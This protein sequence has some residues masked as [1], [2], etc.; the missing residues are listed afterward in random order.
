M[1]FLITVII[2]LMYLLVMLAGYK[3]GF[4]KQGEYY[5]GLIFGILVTALFSTIIEKFVRDI[6][7]NDFH[8]NSHAGLIIIGYLGR[9]LVF[10]VVFFLCRLIVRKL[11]SNDEKTTADRIAGALFGIVK[12]TILIWLLNTLLS[13]VDAFAGVNS[14]L[15]QST[16]Y[17][18]I[19]RFNIV[20]YIF[21]I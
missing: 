2:I 14:F 6:A 9:L 7:V 16:L 8:I 13:K 20:S 12:V 4:L 17:E 19:C 5:I 18:S 15:S 10:A 21:I 11:M 3:Q 1:S